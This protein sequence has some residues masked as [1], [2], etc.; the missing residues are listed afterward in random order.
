M[1][2]IEAIIVAVAAGFAVIVVATILVIIGVHQEERSKT[3]LRGDLPPTPCA[4]LARWVV[5]AYVQMLPEGRAPAP[6]DP[7]DEEPPWFE[8]PVGPVG[9]RGR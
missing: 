8:R 3:F 9:P 7:V 6:P 4:L 2:A 5:G 1:A